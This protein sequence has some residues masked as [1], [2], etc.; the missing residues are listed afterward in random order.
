MLFLVFILCHRSHLSNSCQ[1]PSDTETHDFDSATIGIVARLDELHAICVG[2]FGHGT[3][4]SPHTV[5]AL[6]KRNQCQILSLGH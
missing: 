5:C 3:V 1:M 4:A 2:W 6:N